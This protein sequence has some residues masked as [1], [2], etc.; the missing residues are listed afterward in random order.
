MASANV[1]LVMGLMP[2]PDADLAQLLRDES[3]FAEFARTIAPLLHPDF[4]TVRP[5]LPGGRS[6]TGLDG[7]RAAWLDW[8]APWETYR[9][10]VEKVVDVGQRVLALVEPHGRL[11]G[12]AQEVAVKAG[13]VYVVRDRKISRMEIYSSRDEALGAVG[14][15]EAS[16]RET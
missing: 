13:S 5:G 4:E 12:S 3:L 1:E 11:E 8:T 9:I 16:P 6:Y 2:A 14:L 7:W 15:A 10:K